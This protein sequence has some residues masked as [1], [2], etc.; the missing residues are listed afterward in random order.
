MAVATTS[1]TST[2]DRLEDGAVGPTTKIIGT[3]GTI[4]LPAPIYR[5]TEFTVHLNDVKTTYKFPIEVSQP[6]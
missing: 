2:S 5:P 6:L 3:I 4:T 1:L